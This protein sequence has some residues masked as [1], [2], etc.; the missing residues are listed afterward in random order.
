MMLLLAQ[1][2][3]SRW[4][5]ICVHVALWVLVFLATT[6]LGGSAP[7]LRDTVA[8]SAAAQ[9][10][11]PVEKLA[12]LLAPDNFPKS[13]VPTNGTSMFSTRHFIPPPTPAPPAPTTRKV[14]IT[15]SGFYE[16]GEARHV[17]VKLGNAYVDGSLGARVTTNWFFSD[18]SYQALILTNISGQTNVLPLNTKKEI[19]VPI[20]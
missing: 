12:R 7:P 2:F 15:Y 10:P 9:S 14:E 19:E 11:A 16:A 20:L 5:F 6:R 1:L 3:R 8:L 17:I 18:A 4:F 13:I